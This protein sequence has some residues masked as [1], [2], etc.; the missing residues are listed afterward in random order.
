MCTARCSWDSKCLLILRTVESLNWGKKQN[1][2]ESRIRIDVLASDLSQLITRNSEI[3][4]P[5]AV[6]GRAVLS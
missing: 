2:T 1:E 5:I 3:L 6:S 4:D